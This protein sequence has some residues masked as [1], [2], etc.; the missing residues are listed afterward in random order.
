M[1]KFTNL[2]ALLLALVMVVSLFAGCTPKNPSD[3]ETP[4]QGQ[5]ENLDAG[6]QPV[7]N[8]DMFPLK[9]PVTWE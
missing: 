7:I 9:K 1:K 4:S 2:L 6:T 8:N 3:S 5:E